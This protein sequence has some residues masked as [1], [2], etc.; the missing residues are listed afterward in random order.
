MKCIK[1]FSFLVLTF[2]FIRCNSSNSST[3]NIT[4]NIQK[5][6]SVQVDTVI[7]PDESEKIKPIDLVARKK[8][9]LYG[10]IGEHNLESISAFRGA[11]TLENYSQ[12]NGKWKGRASA[13][14]M[15]MREGYDLPISKSDLSKLNSM[16]LVVGS[17]LFVYLSC[18]N[19][20]FFETNYKE[21]GM[22]YSIIKKPDLIYSSEF[23]K[24][25]SDKSLFINEYLYLFAKG[26]LKPSEVDYMDINKTEGDMAL[27]KYNLKE[28]Q[29]ELRLFNNKSWN[30]T[31]CYIFK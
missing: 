25:L 23:P 6:T 22:S 1:L 14:M 29:F 18:N 2:F 13:L 4:S 11:N 12:E 3:P 27:L 30:A 9:L 28:K 5:P 16:K 7:T 15:G 17:D 19:R 8:E 10:L 21:N 31:T 24:E 20:K 26:D